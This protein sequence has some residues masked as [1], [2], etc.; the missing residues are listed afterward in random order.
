MSL[1]MLTNLTLADLRLTTA[2]Q[3]SAGQN[4]PSDLY[5]PTCQPRLEQVTYDIQARYVTVSHISWLFHVKERILLILHKTQVASLS[6][7]F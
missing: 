7:Y 6:S 1:R 2:Q 3:R 4:L 5:F